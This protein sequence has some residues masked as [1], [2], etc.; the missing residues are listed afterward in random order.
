MSKNAKIALVSLLFLISMVMPLLVDVVAVQMVMI[1]I[2]WGASVYFFRLNSGANDS[3][4]HHL[5]ELEKL[6]Q[7]KANELP[8]LNI[9]SGDDTEAL[10][11]KI[12][13]ISKLY[14]QN[15]REDMKVAGEAVL[16]ASRIYKGDFGHRVHSSG[17]S[18]QLKVLARSMNKMLD[19]MEHY[20]HKAEETLEEYGRGSFE[21]TIV[22]PHTEAD[23]KALFSNVN[24][25]GESL[26][27]MDGENREH[28]RSIQ[29]SSVK[30]TQ[31]IG[32]LQSN[33]IAELD[34][35]ISSVTEKIVN[36]S[37]QEN[38]LAVNLS[39]LSESAENIKTVL[40]VIGDIAD[41]TN[42]LALNAAIE[43]ARAGEHGRGFAVVADEVRK[44]AERTQKSLSESH[45][46]INIV[47]QSIND[48]SEKMNKN[49]Q[50]ITNISDEVESVSGKMQEVVAT[51]NQLSSER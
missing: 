24:Q 23:I 31:A 35:I 5:G 40:S 45:S 47:V 10:A 2:T 17:S 15:S 36:A 21:T 4:I 25:L 32:H 33:T 20:I 28:A 19:Q 43:A 38:E 9:K 42:L 39:Q 11:R 50:E 37:H 51:L 8:E 7:F 1:A 16:L 13:S 18:P 6:L 48:S 30:L 49:A 46:S 27:R 29:E 44:L 26:Q 12:D 22:C 3:L 14:V 34:N 41:Q